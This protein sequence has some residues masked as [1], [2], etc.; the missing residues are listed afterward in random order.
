MKRLFLGFNLLL[1][2]GLFPFVAHGEWNVLVVDAVSEP[3]HEFNVLKDNVEEVAGE[4]VTYAQTVST[5][6][7]DED[8]ANYDV[9]WLGWNCSSD[10]GN[11]FR[12]K[13]ADQIAAY[14]EAGGCLLTSATDNNGWKSDWLPADFTVLDTGDYDLEVTEEGKELFSNPNDVDPGSLIMDERYTSIDDAYTVLAWAKGME[15]S[16]A[17]VLQITL[18]KGLYLLAS[19]DN[20]DV[21][22]TQSNLPLMENMLY[23]AIAFAEEARAVEPS[24]K[25]ATTWASIKAQ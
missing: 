16:D 19:I 2:F 24:D 18:G 5:A 23:Y 22:K 6:L 1:L 9:V 21:G 11:Y 25:L 17:G 20:R 15:G 8:L 10:D 7:I 13:D 14:V 3:G 4:P 12:D